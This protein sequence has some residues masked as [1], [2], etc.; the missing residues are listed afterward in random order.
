[1]FAFAVERKAFCYKIKWLAFSLQACKKLGMEQLD[2][3]MFWR[4]TTFDR[5]IN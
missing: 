4:K 2:F 5:G 3:C 1:M